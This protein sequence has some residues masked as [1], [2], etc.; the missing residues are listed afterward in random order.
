MPARSWHT[1]HSEAVKSLKEQRISPLSLSSLS[2][3]PA[4]Q[5]FPT[6]TE[7]FHGTKKLIQGVISAQQTPPLTHEHALAVLCRCTCMHGQTRCWPRGA[8]GSSNH[9][10]SSV[11][12][13]NARSEAALLA[14]ELWVEFL[15]I[16]KCLRLQSKV[17]S[18]DFF[19]LNCH[20]YIIGIFFSMNQKHECSGCNLGTF[21]EFVWKGCLFFVT[22]TCPWDLIST[23]TPQNR[24]AVTELCI[25]YSHSAT[26][27]RKSLRGWLKEF[28]GH[29]SGKL[30]WGLALA[31]GGVRSY[32]ADH[33]ITSYD[34]CF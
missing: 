4:C 25:V 31:W 21:R 8:C 32:R 2:L 19:L 12:F 18:M 10:G 17:H 30:I 23:K 22:L 24:S 7:W 3:S 14:H 20:R 27:N 1:V 16:N 26:F 5:P 11:T 29:Y 28:P 15:Y 6:F 9:P 13:K 34:L 33:N